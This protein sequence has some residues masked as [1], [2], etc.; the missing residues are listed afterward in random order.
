MDETDP[1]PVAA[2]LVTAAPAPGAV[3]LGDAEPL[4]AAPAPEAE[5][6]PDS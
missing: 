5:S 3:L 2:T 1:A 4:V 6:D